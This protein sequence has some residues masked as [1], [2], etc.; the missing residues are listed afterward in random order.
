MSQRKL[1][2][3]N[4]KMNGNINL[5]ETFAD[6]FS[7]INLADKIEVLICPPFSYLEKAYGAF[8]EIG[9]SV[10]AQDCHHEIYGAHTGNVSSKMVKECGG[11]YVIIGHSE[12]RDFY[13]EED[14]YFSEKVL[15]SIE[16]DLIPIICVG[17][18]LHERNTN[19]TET[20]LKNQLEPFLIRELEKI[21]FVIAYEPKWAIGTGKIASIDQINSAHN[22]IRNTISKKYNGEAA[23]EKRIIYGGSV[24]P[25]NCVEILNSKVV[26]GA[27]I[28]GASLNS[29]DFLSIIE[30]VSKS[31]N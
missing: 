17:E 13:P 27:L 2:A 23:G 21:E 31:L 16:C 6:T 3:G 11:S 29:K 24:K 14:K 28:G 12:R 1:I 20:T 22:F 10:G 30:D 8:K 9:I 26:D 4:W 5:I 19:K 18:N 7:K 15:R 25:N